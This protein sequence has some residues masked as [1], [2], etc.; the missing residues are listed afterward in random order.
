M[1]GKTLGIYFALHFLRNF[2]FVF[3]LF[4]GLITA[5]DVIDLLPRISKVIEVTI[6]DVLT[7]SL[8]RAPTFLEGILPFAALFAGATSLLLLSRKL[9]LV[10]ARASGVSVWQFLFPLV[11]TAMLLGVGTMLVLNPVSVR[12]LKYSKDVEARVL[13]KVRGS[14]SKGADSFWLR[15]AQDDGSLVIRA[16][17]QREQG[18]FLAGVS[19]YSFDSKFVSTNR[20]DAKT[21][22]FTTLPNQK[23][24]Y[25][26]K[27]V[28]ISYP[29]KRAERVATMDIPVRISESD[30]A[31][32][33]ISPRDV[34]FWNLKTEAQRARSSGRSGLS[35]DTRYQSFLAKPFL[36]AAMVLLAASVSLR[37]SR[38][39]NN[40]KVIFLGVLSGFLLFAVA[41][42]V[43]AFGNSGLVAPVWAAFMPPTVALMVAATV[44]L[45]Q[46]DG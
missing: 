42:L 25:R 6:W 26:L 34:S 40:V 29:G 28:L 7:I 35:F 11:L 46:E 1:I 27:D 32:S 4:F 22:D 17:V 43:L 45:Y 44:L 24:V 38:F 12:A 5:V 30:L 15:I 33:V 21:A 2:L 3:L 10:V 18:R 41:R 13:G 8:M 16:S 14:V 23:S 39:G 19:I 37:L 9:E 20:I 31:A 36:L